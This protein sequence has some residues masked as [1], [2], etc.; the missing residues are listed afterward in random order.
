MLVISFILL[1]IINALQ[2][3]QRHRRGTSMS[4]ANSRTVRRA[5]AGTTETPWVRYTLITAGAGLHAAVP[6][7]AAGRR[8]CRGAAQRLWR[9]PGR[10]A[11]ADAWSAIKLTL[12]TALIAVPLNLVFGVAAAWCIAKYEFKGKAF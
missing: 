5:Q 3:W 7:A 8:V 9:V 10:P 4:G 11:R 2:T 6:G 1:L 12:I